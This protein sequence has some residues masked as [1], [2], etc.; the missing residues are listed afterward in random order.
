MCPGPIG[1]AQTKILYCA[2]VKCIAKHFGKTF[3]N[4]NPKRTQELL[5]FSCLNKSH[6]VCRH[7]VD[8]ENE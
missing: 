2:M 8:E 6:T 7:T 1:R 5:D 3:Y 4:Q